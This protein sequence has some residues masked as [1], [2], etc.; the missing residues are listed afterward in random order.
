MN[1]D[2]P[3]DH[4]ASEESIPDFFGRFLHQHQK[5]FLQ[6]RSPF[7]AAISGIGGGKS[8]LG[9]IEIVRYALKF[10]GSHHLVVAPSYR[11]LD[12][13]SWLSLKKV[14]SWWGESL[15][16]TENISKK[17]VTF[18]NIINAH[19]E[20]SMIFSGTDIDPEKI[21]G[22]NL[23]TF[24][25]DEAAY[26]KSSTWDICVGRLRQP[27]FPHRGWTTTSPRGMNWVY[28]K[29]IK[30]PT[31]NYSAVRWTTADNPLYVLEPDYLRNLEETYGKDS[32][33][34]Q[35]EM[36]GEFVKFEGLVYDLKP[37]HISTLQPNNPQ[38]IVCGVDW[39]ITKPGCMI[40]LALN[41]DGTV[42]ILDEIYRS[43]L[44]VSYDGTNDWVSMA[45]NL[46]LKYGVDTFYADPA[47]PN[48]IQTFTMNGI[49]TAPANNR[50][51]PGIRECISRFESDTIMINPECINLIRELGVYEWKQNRTGEYEID[52]DAVKI[53]DHALD[54]MRYGIMG[55]TDI[56]ENNEYQYIDI[57][58][59]GIDPV[60]IG[61]G[62]LR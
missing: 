31:E 2:R 37:S 43:D 20:P 62:R 50:R 48:A 4:P 6:N 51:L 45:R 44:I 61:A 41:A 23:S 1:D 18:D 34:Y 24:W 39:G 25:M 10:P 36:L 11:M 59:Y 17:T 16:I 35:Q 53:D 12:Q 15:Q 22:M 5:E 54:A 47:D 3:I 60:V 55:L 46:M 26:C 27:G 32:K 38:R 49:P 28:D 13:S 30:N 14:I 9:A 21:R 7:R 8:I 19:G 52:V 56:T 57:S 33:F 29:F 40:V 42:F 58:D